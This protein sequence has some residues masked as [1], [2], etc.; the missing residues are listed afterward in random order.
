MITPSL[1]AGL[2]QLQALV[3]YIDAGEASASIVYYATSKPDSLS[4]IPAESAKLATLTFPKPCFKRL[5]LDSIE[6]HPTN[7]SLAIKT[8]TAVW[9]RLFNGLGEAVAD[10]EMGTDIVLNN[11]DL[12]LGATQRLESILL[13]P[14]L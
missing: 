1:K 7:D 2:A 8:G 4:A 3:G 10:F 11:Y 13:K 9:A 14:S 6:L 12:V 5:N